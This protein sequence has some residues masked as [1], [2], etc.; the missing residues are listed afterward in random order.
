LCSF[1][2]TFCDLRRDLS[3]WPRT[4]EVTICDLQCRFADKDKELRKA[5]AMSDADLVPAERIEKAILLIRGQKVLLDK[6]LARLYGVP[7]GRLN[8]QVRR[9]RKRFPDDFMFQL[10]KDEMENWRSQFAI[11]NSAAKMGLRRRPY[12]FTE[13][14][15][16]MLS[17][18]LN[19][20]RAVEVNIAI[21]RAFV[22]LRE[23]MSTHKDLARKL[24][25][26]ERK[27]AEHDDKF[28]V[29]FEA[30]RQLMVPPPEIE[31]KRRIGFARDQFEPPTK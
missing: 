17:S 19:S 27:L 21:M 10:S 14:G 31:K 2:V 24:D 12:A 23:I 26:L 15:V 25:E 9:N 20:D 28:A 1:K 13:Q 8:E 3:V 5:H 4:L 18:V 30:I 16:A 7:T 29:V 11:S 22:R 6:D